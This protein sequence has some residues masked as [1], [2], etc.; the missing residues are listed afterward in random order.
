MQKDEL[1]ICQK[2]DVDLDEAGT[3]FKAGAQSRKR[4][5]GMIMIPICHVMDQQQIGWLTHQ[6]LTLW[7]ILSP[8][9]RHS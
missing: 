3:G 6:L 5:R 1:V 8:Q 2:R 9:R 4:S 7:F